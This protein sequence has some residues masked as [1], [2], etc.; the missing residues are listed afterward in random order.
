[1]VLALVTR[2]REDSEAVAL[3]LS[4]R[5]IDSLIEPLLDIEPVS[6]A[7]IDPAGLQGLL[8]TSANGARA[9]AR[10]L[11]DRSLPVWA[12]GDSSARA[13]RALGFTRVESAQGDVETLADLVIDRVEPARGALLHAAGETVAGDLS[14]RLEARGFTVRRETVY[15]AVTARA[16]SDEAATALRAGRIDMALFFSPRTADTFVNLLTDAGLGGTLT[17]IEAYGLSANVTAKLAPLPWA[18]LHRAAEPTLAALLAAIDEN[19]RRS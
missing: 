2:P 11:P 19:G 5:G 16:L 18:A 14:G 9:V 7:A 17:R 3:A 10:L 4:A 1:M 12:V 6:G 15:R 8:V 13:A